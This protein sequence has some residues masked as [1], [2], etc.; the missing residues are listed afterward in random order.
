MRSETCAEIL[1][2]KVAFYESDWDMPDS[3]RIP[4]ANGGSRRVRLDSGFDPDAA[5]AQHWKD[6]DFRNSLRRKRGRASKAL[7]GVL[8]HASS[9]HQAAKRGNRMAGYKPGTFTRGGL[10]PFEKTEPKK[11]WFLDEKSRKY[12][13]DKKD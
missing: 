4:D 12:L 1:M 8:K 5:W 9:M 2:E 3:V 10:N 7:K 6:E 11:N 13:I